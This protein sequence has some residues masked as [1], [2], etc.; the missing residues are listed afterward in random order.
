VRRSLSPARDRL[1]PSATG[2]SGARVGAP[3]RVAFR[4]LKRVGARDCTCFAA[5][6]LAYALPCRRFARTLTSANARLGADLD[7]YAFLVVGSHHQPPAG[8]PAH[9]DQVETSTRHHRDP[10]EFPAYFRLQRR[11]QLT[12]IAG[13]Q[14]LAPSA[15]RFRPALVPSP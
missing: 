13:S 11:R 4:D 8:L 12:A 3:E 6:W 2:R 7:R 5:Q 1:P 9:S 10:I 14:R 15:N